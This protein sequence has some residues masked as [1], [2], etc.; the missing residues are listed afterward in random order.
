MRALFPTSRGVQCL[1]P[2]QDQNHLY[3]HFHSHLAPRRVCNVASAKRQR[4]APHLPPYIHPAHTQP[5][6]S[7][8]LP[9]SLV[10]RGLAVAS[11]CLESGLWCRLHRLQI[12]LSAL[13]AGRVT[14]KASE[15]LLQKNQPSMPSR[16]AHLQSF[17][18]V[19]PSRLV[20]STQWR[21]RTMNRATNVIRRSLCTSILNAPFINFELV[22]APIWT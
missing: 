18:P 20:K 22:I 8:L 14:P 10:Y 13:R 12:N 7:A 2:S 16:V 9:Y 11:S 5:R 19:L 3:F 6:F 4:A 1:G 17:R 15:R 21:R